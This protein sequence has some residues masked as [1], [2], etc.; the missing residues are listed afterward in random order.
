MI[1]CGGVGLQVV[2]AAALA[3]AWP[4][5]AIDRDP[6]KL[7]IARRRGATHVVDASVV[8]P[9]G[10]VIELT[11]AASIMPSRSSGVPRRSDSRGSSFGRPRLRSLSASPQRASRSRSRRST[12]SPTRASAAPTT[13]RATLPPTS[14]RSPS[15][16][17]RA[18]ST[19]PMSSRTSRI[20]TAST[21][22]STA[23][24]V[25]RARAPS[26]CSTPQTAGLVE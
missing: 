10:A 6:A 17:S 26:S 2:A 24:G 5:I 21:M 14:L 23:S 19:C 8:D 15:S 16:R 12:S 11:Q 9:L 3:G 22:P 25:A 20:S 4:L 7:E 18:S 13:A 1:G